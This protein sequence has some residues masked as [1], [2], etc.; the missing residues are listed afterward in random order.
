M[1]I[2]NCKSREAVEKESIGEQRRAEV[3][4]VV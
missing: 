1:V 3:L 2:L 4:E